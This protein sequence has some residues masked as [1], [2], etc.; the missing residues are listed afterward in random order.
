MIRDT[1]SLLQYEIKKNSKLANIYNN[2]VDFSEQQIES[3]KFMKWVRQALIKKK[4]D[5]ENT[6]ITGMLEKYIIDG[7][8]PDPIG[9]MYRWLGINEFVYVDRGSMIEMKYGDLIWFPKTR[10]V[11]IENL[12]SQYIDARL[13]NKTEKIQ[14]ISKKNYDKAYRSLIDNKIVL[15]YNFSSPIDSVRIYKI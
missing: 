2:L 5:L 7:Y 14:E 6:Y 9:M 10:G 8:M 12:F 15:P 3:L 1:E 4:K 13:L 11:F